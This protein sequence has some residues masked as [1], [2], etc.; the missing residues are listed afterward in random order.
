MLIVLFTRWLSWYLIEHD[1]D[2]LAYSW[3]HPAYVFSLFEVT[4]SEAHV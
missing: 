2:W 4:V 3:Q 1:C